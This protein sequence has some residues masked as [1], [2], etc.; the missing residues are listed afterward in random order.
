M[1]YD[2]NDSRQWARATLRGHIATTLTTFKDDLSIDEAAL[3]V[4]VDEL[5]KLEC[6]GG[7]YVN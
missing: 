5:Q 1:T 4:Q 7:I 2:V 6:T 3:R